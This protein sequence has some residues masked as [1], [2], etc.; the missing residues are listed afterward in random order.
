MTIF[1]IPV[2]AEIIEHIDIL[3]SHLASFVLA[4]IF[5]TSLSLIAIGLFAQWVFHQK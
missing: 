5:S 4:N 2:C 3:E 1:F